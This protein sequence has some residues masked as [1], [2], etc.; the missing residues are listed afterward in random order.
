MQILNLLRE[1]KSGK[2]QTANLGR[3]RAKNTRGGTSLHGNLVSLRERMR[4]RRRQR[5]EERE[6]EKERGIN[7][8]EKKK[9]FSFAISRNYAKLYCAECNFAWLVSIY[10]C[11]WFFVYIDA[12]ASLLG[13][14]CIF[15][16]DFLFMS[17]SGF[18]FFIGIDWEDSLRHCV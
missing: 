5:E 8:K 2:R 14:S 12:R 18:F 6:G 16:K 11:C 17:F 4:T 3:G 1:I 7:L 13:I 15:F 9:K 10:F